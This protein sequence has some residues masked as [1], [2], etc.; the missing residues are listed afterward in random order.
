MSVYDYA[1]QHDFDKIKYANKYKFDHNEKTNKFDNDNVYNVRQSKRSEAKFS[2][3]F[4]YN[5]GKYP[6]YVEYIYH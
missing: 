3:E 1:E 6:K 4:D 5:S 2:V